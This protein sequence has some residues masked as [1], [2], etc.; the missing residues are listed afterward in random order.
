MTTVP[1]GATGT[2]GHD[3]F[4]AF[5]DSLSEEGLLSRYGV[6]ALQGALFDD[7]ILP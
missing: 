2:L 3:G 5:P 6:L 4:L 7:G 1:W